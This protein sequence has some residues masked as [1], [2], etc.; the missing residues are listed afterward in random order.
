MKQ[1]LYPRFRN[2]GIFQVISNVSSKA[3]TFLQVDTPTSGIRGPTGFK[4]WD[5][6]W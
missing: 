4:P 6:G 5:A 2:R 1:R 3:Y